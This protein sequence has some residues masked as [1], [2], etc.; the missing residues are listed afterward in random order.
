MGSEMCIRDRLYTMH[1][2]AP[3]AWCAVT[4][5]NQPWLHRLPVLV[6]TSRIQRSLRKPPDLHT[7]LPKTQPVMCQAG[8]LVR[9]GDCHTGDAILG[10]CWYLLFAILG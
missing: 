9:C 6:G 10:C 8:N 1:R 7:A 5:S 2:S 3:G 4:C